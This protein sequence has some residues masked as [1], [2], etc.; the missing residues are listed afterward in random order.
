ME[1]STK[2]IINCFKNRIA[3]QLWSRYDETMEEVIDE[4]FEDVAIYI[5][6]SILANKKNLELDDTIEKGKIIIQELLKV[7]PKENT[8]GILEIENMAEEYLR[9]N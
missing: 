4:V 6:Q 5:D 7:L 9:D 3:S 8:E 2:E 1:K